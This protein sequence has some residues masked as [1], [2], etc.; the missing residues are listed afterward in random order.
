MRKLSR[1]GQAALHDSRHLPRPGDRRRRRLV[2]RSGGLVLGIVAV[3]LGAFSIYLLPALA[4]VLLGV[5][6]HIHSVVTRQRLFELLAA[7]WCVAALGLFTRPVAFVLSGNM[8][9]AYFIGHFPKNF[10]PALNGGDAAILYCFVFLYMAAAGGG[11][12]SIDARRAG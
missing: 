10:F 2:V 3:A 7:G 6:C 9:F 12:W 5:G 4:A 11:P 1:R 8:A